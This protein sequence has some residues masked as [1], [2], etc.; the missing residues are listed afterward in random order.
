MA[1]EYVNRGFQGDN[2]GKP[3][4]SCTYKKRGSGAAS[5]GA[6]NRLECSI[7]ECP[8]ES[9]TEEYTLLPAITINQNNQSAEEDIQKEVGARRASERTPEQ[10]QVPNVIVH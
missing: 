3:R 8:Q 7:V 9:E 4:G 5:N 6:K 10:Q 1:Q 2:E